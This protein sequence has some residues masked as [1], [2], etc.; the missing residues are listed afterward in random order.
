MDDR[1]QAARLYA[2]YGPAVYRRC[3]RVLGDREAARDATQEVFVKLVRNVRRLDD[4]DAAL[5]WMYRVAMNHCLN[6]RR[7]AARRGEEALDDGLEVAPR[8]QAAGWTDRHLARSVLSRFDPQTQAV[9]FGVFVDGMDR[10]EV[11][12]A[13]GISR[14]TV[15]RKLDRFLVRAR[16]LLAGGEP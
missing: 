14:R 5:P 12:R 6:V 8:A 4:P 11:A 9:A 15:T 10:E 2:T 13:L 7:D 16:K 3:L 1:E